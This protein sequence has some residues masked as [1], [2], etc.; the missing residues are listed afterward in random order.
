MKEYRV[1]LYENGSMYFELVKSNDA[2]DEEVLRIDSEGKWFI[3]GYKDGSGEM[4]QDVR[5]KVEQ[6]LKMLG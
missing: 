2:I 4:P 5:D 1:K 3:D 6:L